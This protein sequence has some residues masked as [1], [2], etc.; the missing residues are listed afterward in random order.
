[1]EE[2]RA[3]AGRER[4]S[5]GAVRGL[6]IGTGISFA[7]YLL[8]GWKVSWFPI[9]PRWDSGTRPFLFNSLILPIWA[10]ISIAAARFCQR[11]W[12]GPDIGSSTVPK[13]LQRI[14]LKVDA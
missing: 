4:R 5:V 8:L 2:L 10:L 13:L 12:A 7:I 6:A 9:K 14:K 1:M 11:F 3:R